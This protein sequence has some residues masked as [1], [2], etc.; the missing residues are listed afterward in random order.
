MRGNQEEW[1]LA[2]LDGEGLDDW[3]IQPK[4]GGLATAVL[5]RSRQHSYDAVLNCLLPQPLPPQRLKGR[6]SRDHRRTWSLDAHRCTFGCNSISW[7]IL[8]SPHAAS[9]VKSSSQ[10]RSAMSEMLSS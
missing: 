7:R 6:Q 5:W 10:L 1:L 4:M 8:R 3:A 9:S 2:W